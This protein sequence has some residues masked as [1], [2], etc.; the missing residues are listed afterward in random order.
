MVVILHA[1]NFVCLPSLVGRIPSLVG[2][3][4]LAFRSII[5]ICMPYSAQ[6]IF[7]FHKFSVNT[8]AVNYLFSVKKYF[9]CTE[10]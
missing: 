5:N 7:K 10:K 9:K 6:Q 1:L 8:Y 4:L 2:H 3:L